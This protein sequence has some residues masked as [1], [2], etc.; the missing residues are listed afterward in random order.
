MRAICVDDERLLMEDTVST[1]LELPEI[2]EAKGFVRP[3]DALEYLESTSV[4]LAILDIDMPGMNGIELAAAIKR[5]HPETAII[6][7]TGYSQYAVE[8]FAVR[9]TGYL[10]KPVAREKLAEDVRYALSG[11]RAPTTWS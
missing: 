11:K 9:A 10:L 4:D 6:F 7:L 1:C 5:R 3:Q 2:D 8:A